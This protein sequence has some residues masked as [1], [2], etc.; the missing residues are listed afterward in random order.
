MHDTGAPVGS[1]WSLLGLFVHISRGT[2]SHHQPRLSPFPLT[3]V[4][5]CRETVEDK[6]SRLSK[7]LPQPEASWSLEGTDVEVPPLEALMSGL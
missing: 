6:T 4:V 2:F 3:S 7:Q 1:W 5:N